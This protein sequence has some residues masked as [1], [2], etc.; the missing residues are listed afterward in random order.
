[1]SDAQA[2]TWGR[3]LLPCTACK[4]CT[5]SDGAAGCSPAPILR[6]KLSCDH[7]LKRVGPRA[8]PLHR[9][10]YCTSCIP[11]GPRATPQHRSAVI[12]RCGIFAIAARIPGGSVPPW[13]KFVRKF[14]RDPCRRC[15][16]IHQIRELNMNTNMDVNNK[17]QG[18][19]L[20]ILRI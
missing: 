7:E 20:G 11:A 15:P 10:L 19:I 18:R 3:G 13:G 5:G 9:C 17:Q 2:A 16:Q 12:L 8:A 14:S 4:D 1:M 6:W